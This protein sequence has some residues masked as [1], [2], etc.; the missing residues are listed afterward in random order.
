MRTSY[1]VHEVFTP[2]TQAQVNFVDRASLN[3]QLMDAIYTSGKQLI[4]Y[5]ESGSGKSTLLMNKLRNSYLAYITTRCSRAMTY[6]QLLL[7]AFDQLNPFYAQG[8]STNSTKSISP[9]L[10]ASFVS[11]SANISKSSSEQQ[12]RALPPQLTPQRLAEFLGAKSMCWVVEDFH[13]MPREEKIPFAQALKI[14]SDVSTEYPELMVIAIGATDTAREVVE[15]DREMSNRVSELHVPLMTPEELGFIIKNGQELL[16]VNLEP[17]AEGIVEYALGMPSTCHQIALN[18][19]LEKGITNTQK[20]RLA[21]TWRDLDP[22]VRRWISDSSDTI[23]AKLFRALGRR[24]VGKYDNCRIILA[25]VASGPLGGMTFEEILGKIHEDCRDYPEN[26]L[27][28]YLRELA[29]DERGQLL[30]AVADGKWRFI[31]AI[32]HSIVQAMLAKPHQADYVTPQQYIEQAVASSWTDT[33]YSSP[34]IAG[35]VFSDTLGTYSFDMKSY[36]DPGITLYGTTSVMVNNATSVVFG[37][38][39]ATAPTKPPLYR[40]PLRRTRKS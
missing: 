13:K 12:A 6:Q 1:R 14:F 19:C 38:T 26:N 18:A 31:S 4:V 40:S 33:V 27:R 7:D 17:I 5:G 9:A 29:K 28:R 16:N 10:Q 39:V 34:S 3:S 30:K 24:V 36:L 2:S 11:I 35:P 20:V 8:R 21:F 37:N 25:A 23:Q 15:Y 32:F 22:A